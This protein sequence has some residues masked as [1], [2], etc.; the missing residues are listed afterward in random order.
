MNETKLKEM[1]FQV[2]LFHQSQQLNYDKV[3]ADVNVSTN[4]FVLNSEYN[5]HES[6]YKH[7]SQCSSSIGGLLKSRV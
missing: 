7:P 1:G 6:E 2:E 4:S 5:L 3:S